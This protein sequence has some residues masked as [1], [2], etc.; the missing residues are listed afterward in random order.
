MLLS[1]GICIDQ[2]TRIRFR[3]GNPELFLE[4]EVEDLDQLREAVEAGAQ[5]ALLDNFSI[6]SLRA[7]VERFSG[8]ISLEA[9]GGISLETVREI[10]ETGVEFISSGDLTKNIRAIDFSMRYI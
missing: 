2:F 4:V 7:A 5:R 6:E 3:F 9:S 10:A 8:R 1:R